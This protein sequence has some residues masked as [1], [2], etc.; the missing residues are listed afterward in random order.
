M[1]EALIPVNIGNG[2]ALYFSARNGHLEVV[3][4]LVAIKKGHTG[5]SRR[6]CLRQCRAFL[7]SSMNSCLEF[8][9]YLVDHA[10]FPENI[11]N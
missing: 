10:L 7:F 9:R 4:Y 3:K 5:L 6:A 8:V 2:F 1:E 11:K